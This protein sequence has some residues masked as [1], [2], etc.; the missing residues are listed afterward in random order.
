ML[1]GEGQFFLN[2]K[3][4]HRSLHLRSTVSS[5]NLLKE[6]VSRVQ[7]IVYDNHGKLFPF[8]EDVKRDNLERF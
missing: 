7:N 5:Q 4:S 6:S 2:K 8:A 3:L 1:G